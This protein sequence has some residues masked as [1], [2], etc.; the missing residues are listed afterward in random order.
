MN[1]PLPAKALSD[2]EIEEIR[3]KVVTTR[4]RIDRAE[5][6]S[7]EKEVLESMLPDFE[8]LVA[9]IDALAEE[10]EEIVERL[11]EQK[12]RLANYYKN[13][14]VTLAVRDKALEERKADADKLAKVRK[15]IKHYRNT[16]QSSVTGVLAGIEW[17][18]DK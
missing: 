12:T 8:S 5:E 1:T 6:F 11:E 10:R 9:H 3:L 17:E 15:L 2:F 13:L 7:T 16:N 14:E 18:L 4:S